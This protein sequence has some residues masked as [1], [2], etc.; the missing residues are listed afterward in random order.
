MKFA[1]S[2]W[3]ALSLAISISI[4]CISDDGETGPTPRCRWKEDIEGL[5]DSGGDGRPAILGVG[6]GLLSIDEASGSAI[7]GECSG[8]W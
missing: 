3:S 8:D 7:L 2:S 5:D 4:G 1:C 6:N